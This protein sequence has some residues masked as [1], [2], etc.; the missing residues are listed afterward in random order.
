MTLPFETPPQSALVQHPVDGMHTLPHS[1]W[2]VAHEV[3]TQ[4]PF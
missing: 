2:P 4:L 3:G 1:F